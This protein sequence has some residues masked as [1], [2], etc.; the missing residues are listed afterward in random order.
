M[1][2][3]VGVGCVIGG[4]S[5]G[6]GS[7]LSASRV[8]GAINWY[9]TSEATRATGVVCSTNQ[10]SSTCIK[11]VVTTAGQD[12]R[13][14]GSDGDNETIIGRGGA[15]ERVKGVRKRA[16]VSVIVAV[17]GCVGVSRWACAIIGSPDLSDLKGPHS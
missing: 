2:L 6:G 8:I 11:P 3:G 12:G 7:G 10:I 4:F 1:G 9:T 15:G 5:L 14:G 17:G 16:A 13:C